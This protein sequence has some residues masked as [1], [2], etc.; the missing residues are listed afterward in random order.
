MVKDYL[1]VFLINITSWKKHEMQTKLSIKILHKLHL[2]EVA[3]R[4]VKLFQTT[5]FMQCHFSFSFCLAPVII[6]FYAAGKTA[7]LA[8]GFPTLIHKENVP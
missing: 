2:V 5:I 7:E 4:W 6:Y 1:H 3:S 8:Q